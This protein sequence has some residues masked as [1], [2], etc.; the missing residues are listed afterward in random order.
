MLD[1]NIS[2]KISDITDRFDKERSYWLD[3]LSGEPI[4]TMFPCDH[5]RTPAAGQ[6]KEA[7]RDLVEFEITGELLSELM[8]LCKSSDHRLHIILIAVLVILMHKYTGN[9]DIIVGSPIYKQEKEAEFINTVLALRNQIGKNSSFKELLFQV[10]ETMVGA[11]EN[12]N[13][14]IEKLVEELNLPSVGTEFPLFDVAL[15]I[16]NIPDKKYI[17]HIGNNITFSFLRTGADLKGKVEYNPLRYEKETID[18]IVSHFM[19]L[20]R[21][22]FLDI[23]IKVSG[24]DILSEEE[25]KQILF[26]YNNTAAEVPG[27][28]AIHQLFEKQ[29]EETPGNIAVFHQGQEITYKELNE[30]ANQLARFLISKGVGVKGIVGIMVEPSIEMMVGILGILKAGSAYLPIS[31]DLP[32]V[33]KKFMLED[34]SAG[35]LLLQEHLFDSNKDLEEC[36]PPAN[37]FFLDDPVV[38]AKE[39]KGNLQ[40]EVIPGNPVYI[41]YTSGSTGRP[42]GVVLEHRGVVNYMSWAAKTYVKDGKGTFPLYTS[43]SFDLTVTSIFTPLITGNTVVIYSGDQKEFSIQK[44]LEENRVDIIKLTPSHLKLILDLQIEPPAALRSFIVGGEDL[45]TQLARDIHHHFNGDIDIYNEYGPTETVVGS[46]IYRFNPGTDNGQSV[47]IGLPADNTQIYVL[48]EDKKPLP[49]GVS[50]EIFISGH[51]VA[52]GYLNRPELTAEK[53][54]DNPFLPGN[55][56][57]AAGDLGRRFIDIHGNNNMEFLGRGDE[58]VKIRGFRVELGEIENKIRDFNR[59]RGAEASPTGQGLQPLE[60]KK[61]IRCTKCLLPGNFPGIQ[62]NEE[63]ICH[64]CREY[65]ENFKAHLDTYFKEPEDF[66]RLVENLKEKDPVPGK[67]DCLLLFSGGK[68]S[69][70][71]LYQLIDMGLRVLAFTF[72]NS[73]ISETAFKNIKKTTAMLKVDHVVGKVESMN[74]VF[75]ESLKSNHNV[76]HG[77]WHALNTMAV[78][79]AHEKGINLVISGLS[80]GQIFDMRL[81]GLFR[82][83]I[84]NEQE[85]DEKLLSFRKM[86]HSK[87]NMFFRLSH[88][89]LEENALENIQFVDFFRYFNT[90]VHQIREYLSG[91]GWVPPRDTGFCSS[92]CLINDVGIYMFL[93]EEGYHFYAAPLSWDIRLGQV[94]REVGLDEMV[95]EGDIQQMSHILEEIG[96]YTAANV[97]DVVVLN[98]E[99][100]NGNN[101]L[102]AYIVPE[103]EISS[104]ETQL[105][106]YLSFELPD[107]MIPSYFIRVNEIP[108]TASGKIDKKALLEIEPASL[109]M[110][111]TYVE[112][113][114]EKEKLIANLCKEVFKLAKIGVYDN[115]F[116]LGATS[117]SIIQLNNKLQE[118]FKK[119]IPVLTMFEYP[120][121][122]S[123][124]EYM[125]LEIPGPGDSW[126]EEEWVESRKQGQNKFKQ[127]RKKRM[128]QEEF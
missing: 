114:D 27:E 122:A 2:R 15:L 14:P 17:Q 52:R 76:C 8:N 123:F 26:D 88:V 31:P 125:E 50:G 12:Q 4:K 57:Y 112:P 3:K 25:K 34:S 120:T 22:I 108:L 41:I 90:P 47:P 80:R 61:V 7:H 1:S 37:I 63:G 44:V 69:T 42:K 103:T 77:C 95:F 72:D 21:Q 115:F 101:F 121:I 73:Y 39:N 51:G 20:L 33:R 110:R 113:R 70:Y 74:Q 106:E 30:K 13:Y 46:M 117:F 36:L 29:V 119:D 128:K 126:E 124:L 56:M 87:D 66:Y 102:Y 71:V 11:N 100:E 6:A 5:D 18:R 83:G 32:M 82:A 49:I 105:R 92:N 43:F 94:T 68:D 10:K 54:L 65:E 62:F 107:Y 97:K 127:L 48:D 118:L 109:Q 111:V 84:F 86:F 19:N 45:S 28:A 64:L 89:D 59:A 85:I 104:V 75:V 24:I 16:E 79:V 96:Y 53:F 58:Q 116:N 67:Y 60:P 99:D 81:E 55:K 9:K 91:K 78:K 23:D 40:V 35:H 93:K 98:K 38:Y